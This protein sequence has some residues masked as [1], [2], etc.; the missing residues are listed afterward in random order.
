VISRFTYAPSLQGM[1]GCL[2]AFRSQIVR[3]QA[4]R[5]VHSS[6]AAA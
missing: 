6:I 2:S 3:R 5:R 4:S 1:G